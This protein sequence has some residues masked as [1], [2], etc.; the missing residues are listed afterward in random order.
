M[1]KILLFMLLLVNLQLTTDNGSLD[2]GLG[3]IS[4]QTYREEQLDEV[5]VTGSAYVNCDLCHGSVLKT[6]L[7]FHKEY[8]CP[9]RMITCPICHVSYKDYQGH[10]CNG[11][12][13]KC[14]K[15]SNQCTCSMDIDIPSNGSAVGNGS[16]GGGG[17]ASCGSSGTGNSNGIGKTM[18]LFDLKSKTGVMLVPKLTMFTMLHPQTRR[19]ECVVRALAFMSELQG[20]D[21]ATAYSVLT[22]FAVNGGYNLDDPGRGGIP[23]CV[24]ISLFDSYCDVGYG[25]FDTDKIENL[26]DHGYAVGLA[27]VENPPHMVTVIGYDKDFYYTAAGDLNGNVTTYQKNSLMGT[28]YIYIKNLK[29][30]YK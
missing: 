30:P 9:E 13:E 10:N 12:C 27:T 23:P 26:I 19:A 15:P 16:F 17:G 11:V 28:G 1:K 14:G 4:A 5:V 3:E 20:N 25:N 21:Y 29:A 18:S 24:V 6:D 2:I 7:D 8:V 22:R